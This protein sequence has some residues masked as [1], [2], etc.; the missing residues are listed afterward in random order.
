MTDFNTFFSVF[1]SILMVILV[2]LMAYFTSRFV[3]KRYASLAAGKYMQ[4]VD[5]L[6]IGQ[7]QQLLL[8][9]TGGIILCLG[10]SGQHIEKLGQLDKN[11]LVEIIRTQPE[12]DFAGVLLETIK[13]K[14]PFGHDKDTGEGGHR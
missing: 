4:V 8:V 12:G 14:L 6:V 11:D 1:F 3:S 2:V 10:V 13:K 9:E 7:G 5:R